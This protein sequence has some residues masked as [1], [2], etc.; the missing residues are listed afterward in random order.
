MIDT[1][2]HIYLK[3]FDDDRQ[4]M[5]YRAREAGV[6]RMYLPNIDLSSFPDLM[7]LAEAESDI[8]PMVGLHPGS[9]KEDY[10]KQLEG[11]MAE[12]DRNPRKFKAVGEIG[13]DLYWRQDNLEE[14]QKAFRHQIEKSLEHELPIVIHCRD[15]FDEVFECLE[16]YR[17]TALYGIFHCFTGNYEQAQRAIG[18]NLKLGIGG[19]V[20]FKNGGL[21]EV[22]E[23][24]DL[25]HLV[26]ETDAPFLAPKPFRGKRNEPSYVKYVAEKLAEVKNVPLAEVDRIT[27]EN[28]LKIFER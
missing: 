27:T 24:L 25:E 10:Q 28:A 11:L 3:R 13:V 21:A 22:V 18:L 7:N 9:V 17:D 4:E 16:P 2:T 6:E 26:L 8:F 14:Q 15:A 23:D 5:L 1:H 19:V 20:T 12:L